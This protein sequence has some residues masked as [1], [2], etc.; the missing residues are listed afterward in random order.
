MSSIDAPTM[1]SGPQQS[2]IL[3]LPPEL[4]NAI[5]RCVL[6]SDTPIDVSERNENLT[7]CY[8][9]ATCRQIRAEASKM[10]YSENTFSVSVNHESDAISEFTRTWLRATSHN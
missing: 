9:L 4:R 5:Y 2:P 7:P 8:L 3:K 6:I 10:Y 1:S